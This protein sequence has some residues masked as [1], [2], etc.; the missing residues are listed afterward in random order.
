MSVFAK[1]AAKRIRTPIT[2][3]A[4][5]AILLLI[6]ER[7]MI[8]A[9][10]EFRLLPRRLKLLIL[11]TLRE[12][13]FLPPAAAS[14]TATPLCLLSPPAAFAAFITFRLRLLLPASH[15]AIDFRHDATRLH[16]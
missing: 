5:S 13:I 16:S 14:P 7:Q 2:V 4:S 3:T 11:A 9:L 10:A 6:T 8:F 12:L 1:I 15:A